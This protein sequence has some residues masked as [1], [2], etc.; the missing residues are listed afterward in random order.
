MTDQPD[1]TA[2]DAPM[3]DEELYDLYDVRPA[4]ECFAL[5]CATRTAVHSGEC[6]RQTFFAA[7]RLER[8][9]VAAI[10]DRIEARLTGHLWN[11]NDDSDDDVIDDVLALVKEIRSK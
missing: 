2:Q 9:R 8:S 6:L 3:S 11:A 4:S 10:C 5:G 7:L 1:R